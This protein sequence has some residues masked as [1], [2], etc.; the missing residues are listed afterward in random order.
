MQRVKGMNRRWR[1]L[2]LLIM[3]LITGFLIAIDPFSQP[4]SDDPI[5]TTTLNVDADPGEHILVDAPIKQTR[6]YVIQSGDTLGAIFERLGYSQNSLYQLLEADLNLLAFDSIKPGQV[7]LFTELADQ[8]TQVELQFNLAS[9][10]IYT[11]KDSH[12]FEFREVIIPGEWREHRYSGEVEYSFTGSAQ[13][14]G[15]SLAEAQFI[16][17]LLKDKINFR[18]DLRSGDKFNIL[19]SRQYVGEQL[20]GANHIE[21]VEI[22]NRR[23]NIRAYLYEGSYYDEQGQSVEKAFIRYPFKGRYRV[24]SSF[25]PRR[26]HP[27]TGLLRPHNGTD[28][29][30]PLGTPV[31]ATGDGVVTRVRNH[32]YAGI[33]VELSHGKTYRTRYLHLGKALV[34]KGQR[35]KRGQK[36]AQ[37]GNT[38]RSTGPHLH[39]EFHINGRAVNGVTAAIPIAKSISKKHRSEFNLKVKH[40]QASLAGDMLAAEVK[41]A[42]AKVAI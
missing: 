30:T 25:N 5:F 39:Y 35:V 16:Y 18:R 26:R 31:L 15:L 17:D 14:A 24:S 8:L 40:Y 12:G 37:S 10:V 19:I 28:F 3:I 20:T 23:S 36:I 1:L 38:G 22:N 7:L 32:K 13:K 11:R 21:A 6:Q 27:I 33:Y 2:I 9:K 41:E 29:A 34:K 4:G 42:P